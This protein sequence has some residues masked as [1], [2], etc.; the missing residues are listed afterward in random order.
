MDAVEKKRKL[1]LGGALIATLIAVVLVEED[2]ESVIETVEPLQTAKSSGEKIKSQESHSEHLDV[3]QLG[4]RKF[5]PSAG[6]LFVST[7]WVPKR[8]KI[9]QEEQEAAQAAQIAKASAPPPAPTAPP[10]PFKY[11]GKAIA[12]NETW[13]FLSQAGENFIAKIGGKIDGKYRLDSINDNTV[14][15]TYLPL[16]IKQTLTIDNK[17]AGNFQ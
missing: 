16:S 13:V 17:I 10:L 7:T 9:S 8:P 2:K 6:E 5:D 3:S 14:T 4:Q 11:A 12:D 15:M 1:L